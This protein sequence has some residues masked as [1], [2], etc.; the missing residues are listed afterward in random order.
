M[1]SDFTENL[2]QSIDT[3]VSARLANLPYDQTLEC[4]IINI[5]EVEEGKYLVRYQGST[6]I[7]LSSNKTYKIGDMVYVQVP[8]GDF[9]QDKFIVSKRTLTQTKVVKKM[10]FLTFVKNNN[11]SPLTLQ[12]KEFFLKTS[13]DGKETLSSI[14]NFSNF[15]GE[16]IA[17]GY[18]KLGLKVGI[19]VDIPFSVTSGD[20]GVK[21][22]IKGFNQNNTYL[23]VDK[24]TDYE[25]KEFELI[26]KDMISSN[27][28]NTLGYCNQEKTY[29]ITNFVIKNIEVLF[30]QDG[31]FLTQDNTPINGVKI[32][33]NNLSLF[34]GY[35]I[36]E[37]QNSNTRCFL[38]TTAGYKFD[39][40]NYTKP[41]YIRFATLSDNK[42]DLI[43]ETQKLSTNQYTIYWEEYNPNIKTNGPQS[44]YLSYQ[45]MK[46]NDK[47]INQTVDLE[48]SQS[49]LRYSYVV[50]ITD[51]LKH[52]YIS[53][54]IE[55]IKDTYLTENELLDLLTGFFR[56]DDNGNIYLNG[57]MYNDD[58]GLNLTNIILN[59]FI[60]ANKARVNIK[61]SFSLLD[62]DGNTLI[63]ISPSKIK[64]NIPVEYQE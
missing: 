59:D 57:G 51:L 13:G 2:F 5:N 11:L 64:I 52:K 36:S 21:L 53:N 17:A 8:Q 28:Y 14:Y 32:Y 35:D 24:V 54:R 3:I 15:Y 34:L 63:E 49:R 56:I 26:N 47:T 33:F 60:I 44:E 23:S 4:E 46:V 43:I 19:K 31:K 50:V 12:N 27:Y 20:Y 10:P 38:Y 55:F 40:I 41:M 7:A 45:S 9:T 6:F 1:N 29:D 58:N 25:I 16:S 18:T 48:G 30:W 42:S 61:D 22:R 39:N 37:F 62:K